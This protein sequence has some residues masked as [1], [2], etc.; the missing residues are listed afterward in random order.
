MS[1]VLVATAVTVV[2]GA[3]VAV[4]SRDAR[5]ALIGLALALVG[6]PLLAD[7]LPATLPLAARLI[8]AVLAAELLWIAVRATTATT[9]GSLVGWPVEALAAGAAFVVGFAAVGSGGTPAAVTGGATA[10]S[11]ET[12]AV[13]VGA[14]LALAVVSIAPL[15]L[16]RDAFRLAIATTLL[17]SAATILRAG[18]LGTPAALEQLVV[19]GVVVGLGMAGATVV[20]NA[21]EAGGDLG[22]GP[23]PADR[24]GPPAG[25]QAR[26]GDDPTDDPPPAE[27]R[28]SG[29]SR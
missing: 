8:A 18:L 23:R 10:V 22:L 4:S 28:T 13:I 25:R 11:S 3:I 14:S 21:F 27:T 15:V 5:I 2:A 9:R 29:E 12:A 20:G 26:P 6:S 19:A 1:P 17:V 16:G 7:P 24:G